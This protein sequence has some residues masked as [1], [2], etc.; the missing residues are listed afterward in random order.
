MPF[1]GSQHSN[2]IALAYFLDRNI[3]W[4]RLLAVLCLMPGLLAC[5]GRGRGWQKAA[6]GVLLLFYVC[7]FY[8][9][10]YRFLADK[11]FY[12]PVHKRFA[13]A[14]DNQVDSNQ[15]VIGAYLNGE[16][17]A[18][19]IQVIGYHHQ[20]ED[21]LGGEPVLVTYCTVCRTGRVFS[22][23]VQG[24]IQHFRLV[25]MDHFNA[26]FEDYDSHSW[27]RQATGEAIAGPLS[28]GTLQEFPSRQIRL[29]AW[30]RAHPQ[31]RILQPDNLFTARYAELQGYDS[32]TLQSALEKRDSL[33]W[34]K[35][36]WVLGV[37]S[38]GQAKAY[39]WNRLAREKIINDT[40]GGLP[41]LI[42]LESDGVS[43]HVWKAVAGGRPIW[44]RWNESRQRPEDSATHSIW[45]WD[46]KSPDAAWSGIQLS[47]VQAY[48]EFWHSWE[49]FH[50]GTQKD[51]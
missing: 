6:L 31:T 42:A 40:L 35:K 32:G 25:G 22:P 5:F 26:M 15:L 3:F 23:I 36:S 47:E 13:S 44:F 39:D 10:H 20:V 4:L 29:G 34:H 28:G 21:S 50:P 12:P 38:G 48:Q 27:W 45:E 19:P 49:T 17:A 37:L 18:Y 43:F 1:P 14:R 2:S 51:N 8:L 11:M 46:G 16:A 33:S 7:I 30:I 24:K 41:I 9:F